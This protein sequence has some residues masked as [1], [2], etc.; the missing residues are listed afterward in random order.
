MEAEVAALTLR[1]QQI[2]A[3]LGSR[4]VPPAVPAPHRTLCW[5]FQRSVWIYLGRING[6]QG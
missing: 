1:L 3:Q 2:Q 6:V 4:L 5:S